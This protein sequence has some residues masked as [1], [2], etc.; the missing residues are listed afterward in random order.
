MYVLV[1]IFANG[2]IRSEIQR[3]FSRSILIYFNGTLGFDQK[4]Y[5]DM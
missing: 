1:C 3:N 4:A 2:L 5:K